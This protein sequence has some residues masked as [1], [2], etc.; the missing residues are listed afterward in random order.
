[1]YN[2]LYKNL[3][4]N[5]LS[6]EKQFGFQASNSTEHAVIELISQILDAFNENKYALGIFIDLSKVFDTVD[7]NI[8][9]KK[10]DMYGIKGKN[11]KWFHSYLTN[12]KQFIK[13]RDQ[14]TD[15]EFL[16]C[17]VP[18]GSIR[19]P[20]LFV[21]FV[22]D[23]K[24][25]TKLLDPIMFAGDTNFFYTNK[26]IK[27]LFETANKELRYVNEWFL[28]N[29][30]SLNVGKTK[31]LFFHK[32]NACDSI[33]LRLPI[34]N[35]NNIEI[36]RE[37]SV[38]FQGV[39]ID[40]NITWNKHMEL[41]ENKVSKNIGIL[42]RASHYLDK[43]SL[44]SIYFSFIHNYVNYCNIAW[45]STSRTKIDKIL[46][47]QKHAVLIIYNKDKF[48][49]LKPLMRDMNVLNVFQINIFQI[50]KLMYKSKH[51]LNPRVF[52]NTFTEIHHGHPTRFPEAIL[53]NEK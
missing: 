19:G 48:T 9:L 22:N 24:N 6:Y 7:H 26:N 11:L 43:K 41:V 36:K 2:R 16:R 27:V 31:Y 10:L 33:P 34:V 42:Y 52:G 47:K 29:K 25:S 32:P 1:M 49:H 18:Q 13:C 46:K 17:G 53:N 30:L 44:K 4:Q 45:A 5:N 23:L 50:L 14:N 20:L 8:L 12:I 40:E 39:I 37:S 15:L 51:N 35:F 21:I 38:K 3:L 28:A